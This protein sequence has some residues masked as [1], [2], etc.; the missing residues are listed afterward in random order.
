MHAPIEPG[1]FAAVFVALY[2]AHQIGDHWVQT[3][4]EA[5]AKGAL[6]WRG[7]LTCARH[8]ATLT[9]TKALV[10]AVVVLACGLELSPWAAGRGSGGGR[11]LAL[12]GG[13]RR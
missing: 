13:P 5:A 9:A 6:G 3:N 11:G 10:L 12:L 2:A 4:G 8:V 1:V 7:R